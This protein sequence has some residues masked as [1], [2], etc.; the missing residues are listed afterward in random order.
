G[1]VP[2]ARF[3]QDDR[4]AHHCDQSVREGVVEHGMTWAVAPPRF[5]RVVIGA[6]TVG[7]PVEELVQQRRRLRL[8]APWHFLN[9]LP[10]PHQHGSL[11]PSFSC[12]LACTV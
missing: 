5:D 9:F 11:R 3:G 10:E 8:Y 2:A 12:G 7:Y 1:L 6:R 4:L